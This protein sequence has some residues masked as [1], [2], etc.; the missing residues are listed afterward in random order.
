MKFSIN[1]K[2]I[3][4]CALVVASGATMAQHNG[5]HG[6]NTTDQ[7]SAN[8]Q[9]SPYAGQQERAIKSLST[10]DTQDWLDGK[11]MSLAKAA[12]LNGYPGPMHTLELA[13]PLQLS[14]TQR[15]A[16]KQLMM[17]HKDEVR[18]LGADLVQ[19]ERALDQ[20]FV[21]RSIDQAGLKSMTQRI[22]QLQA[23]IRESHLRTH[24]LQTAILTSKQIAQYNTLRG[25]DS[26]TPSSQNQN[27]N[28]VH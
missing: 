15:D 14:D 7:P 6:H 3:L 18:R 17:T 2:I 9:A 13:A 24:L 22:G 27:Q 19:A 4:F 21:N 20:A 11:G 28:H 5:H 16:S 1:Q 25:Y 8:L 12:E 10:Q 23:A 26:Q